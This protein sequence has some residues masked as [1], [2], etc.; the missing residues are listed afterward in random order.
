M[1]CDDSVHQATDEDLMPKQEAML[2]LEDGPLEEAGDTQPPSGTVEVQQPGEDFEEDSLAKM[3]RA[4]QSRG[5]RQGQH[6]KAWCQTQSR[7]V[8]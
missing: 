7:L 2:A 1:V 4:L 8:A 5:R 6:R 3:Q